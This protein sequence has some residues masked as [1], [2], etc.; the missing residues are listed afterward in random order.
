MAQQLG[1]ASRRGL[2][3]TLAA[4]WCMIFVAS[5]ANAVTSHSMTG[6]LIMG[7]PSS[8]QVNTRQ[9]TITDPGTVS[10][11]PGTPINQAS[12]LVGSTGVPQNP[13]PTPGNWDA[14][15]FGATL[16]VPQSIWRMDGWPNFSWTRSG[17]STTGMLGSLGYAPG[18][19]FRTFASFANVAQLTS[20]FTS[21]QYRATFKPGSGAGNISWCPRMTGC[22]GYNP[23]ATEQAYIGVNPGPNQFGGTFRMLRHIADDGRSNIWFAVATTPVF[24][25]WMSDAARFTTGNFD[26][27]TETTPPIKPY[28]PAGMPNHYQLFTLN[29][30]PYAYIN[31]SFKTTPNY[32]GSIVGS[33]GTPIGPATTGGTAMNPIN[34]ADGRSTGFEMTTGSIVFSDSSPPPTPGNYFY[35]TTSGYDHRTANGNGNIV[36]V[37]GGVVYAGATNNKFF[38]VSRLKMTLPEPGIALG[39]GFAL[40][41]LFGLD[42]VRR[43][44]RG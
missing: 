9:K 41:V 14:S 37:G 34:I 24:V 16:T 11:P 10:P 23:G 36:L 44:R 15:P 35:A 28:W 26:N 7:N 33:V 32:V 27:R 25:L 12:R 1:V 17:M 31:G 43:Q 13:T 29:R 2:L 22:A 6:Q 30:T 4:A 5:V 40:P 3:L 8:P 18:K 42:R 20:Y 21:R 19:R 38:R 39:F